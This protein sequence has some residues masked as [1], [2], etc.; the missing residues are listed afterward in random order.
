MDLFLELVEQT[1]VQDSGILFFGSD[2][3][4][5]GLLDI[6]EVIFTV[7]HHDIVADAF[8]KDF[9]KFLTL[10]G[11]RPQNKDGVAHSLADINPRRETI[12]SNMHRRMKRKSSLMA[13]FRV[14]L[15]NS[16]LEHTTSLTKVHV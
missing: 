9:P 10:L 3:D 16:H 12:L 15:L 14:M 5:V 8:L 4:R 6:R 2:D 13:E 7:G 1:P 11:I